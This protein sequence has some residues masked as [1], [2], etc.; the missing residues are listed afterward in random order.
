M[1]KE[2]SKVCCNSV[3][4]KKSLF[5]TLLLLLLPLTASAQADTLYAK[6]N[7]LPGNYDFWIYTPENYE[8][9][10]SLP[11][12][13]FLHGRSLCGR[14]LNR[15]RRYGPLQAVQMGRKIPAIIIAPQNPGGSWKPDK[16]LEIL[17]WTLEN[18]RCDSTR[19]YVL[20]MSLGGYGTMDFC[21]TYP[22]R[23]AAG[24][25]LCGGTTLKD[26]QG[27]GQLPFWILHGTADRAVGIQQSKR[28][29]NELLAQ[30]HDERLRY[31][32]LP[33][34]SHGALARIFYLE[35]TYEWLFAHRLTDPYRPVERD[36]P[37]GNSDLPTAYKNLTRRH[38]TLVVK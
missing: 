10:D 26:W 8:H 30:H 1:K 12:V 6:R 27:L 18:Y 29:V 24:M 22:E 11:I 20:G 21:G 9:L 5:V 34:A 32:W 13:Y 31:D 33:G 14:D 7:V 35:K 25:A 28:V 4:A 37:I 23:I 15:V 2:L 3:A 17:D 19:V 38:N 16:L 36:L